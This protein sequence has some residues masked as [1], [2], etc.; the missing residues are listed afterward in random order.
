[1]IFTPAPHKDPVKRQT[2]VAA[3]KR[4]NDD[5]RGN[6]RMS[7]STSCGGSFDGFKSPKAVASL[8]PEVELASNS[9]QPS[10]SSA[11]AANTAAV[12]AASPAT[13]VS[14]AAAVSPPPNPTLLEGVV[15]VVEVRHRHENGSR[16]WKKVLE[17]LGA[18]VVDKLSFRCTHMIFKDGTLANYRRAKK[19]G[20]HIVAASWVA[21]C[22]E[23][24]QRLNESSWPCVN[25]DRYDSPGRTTFYK[26]FFPMNTWL[27]QIVSLN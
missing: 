4:D 17:Q 22:K 14:K 20:L 8:L 12:A 11:A 16:V 27:V 24:N 6:S 7:L 1:M 15:A 13:T 18:T 26:H 3:S 9:P 23:L 10:T 2:V 25:Q 5:S 19:L 21:K